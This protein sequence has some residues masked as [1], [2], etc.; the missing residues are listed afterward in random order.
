MTVLADD[1]RDPLALELLAQ[2]KDLQIRRL[3]VEH[4]CRIAVQD[5]DISLAR[6][7]AARAGELDDEHRRLTRAIY[8]AGAAG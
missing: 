1:Q 6:R 5:D 3:S 2:V 4:L 7:H 8:S